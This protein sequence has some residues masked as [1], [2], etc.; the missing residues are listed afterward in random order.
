MPDFP[1]IVGN[2]PYV[3]RNAIG[4][5][6]LTIAPRAGKSV[7]TH[8]FH[9]GSMKLMRAHYLDK[10]GQV[11]YTLIIPGGGY[12]GGDDYTLDITVEEGGSLLLTGQGATKVYRT[13]NDYSAQ[14]MTV[15]QAPNSVFEYIPDQLILYRDSRYR[16]FTDAYLDSQSSFLTAEIITP[17]WDPKG[18]S[19]LYDEARL[20]T[21]LF[22]DGTLQ[23]IDNL[24]VEPKGERFHTDQMVIL[25]GFTH[26]ATLLA[27]DPQLN[28][29]HVATLRQ[30]LDEYEGSTPT[31]ASIT[32]TQGGAL[33]VR[34]LGT[35]TEDLYKLMLV[36]ADYLR[37]EFRGQGPINLRK[38]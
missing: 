16:Q 34:A 8:Q 25:E 14:V 12:L 31:R 6:E 19:F 10:S 24:Y 26:V 35:L 28:D 11:Y 23:V 2:P 29:D 38:Y 7:A 37:A 5:L 13:P 18:G 36:V 1:K 15:R 32:R 33:A 21:R 4:E 9:Q 22:I 17:G 30:M 3:P 20:H 27:Y